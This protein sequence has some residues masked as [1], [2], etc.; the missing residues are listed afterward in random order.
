MSEPWL[1][2][3]VPTYNGAAYLAHTLDSIAMQTTDGVEVI[4]VDDGSS[5]AT[6]SILKSYESR[7]P[8]RILARRR[9]GNWVANTNWGLAQARGRYACFLHQ[10]D[11]W[12]PDR[13][14]MLR[15]WLAREPETTLFLHPSQ[16]ID[17]AGRGLGVWRCPLPEGRLRSELVIEQL[18]VQN[19]VAVPAPVFARAAALRVGGLDEALW[20]TAD[21]DFWLKLAA[22]GP[23]TYHARPLAAFRIHTESQT[24]QG[25]SRAGDMRTQIEIVLQRHLP[26]W[27][28]AN[29]GRGAV[30]RTARMSL[31][32]NHALAAW[33]HGD[34]PKWLTLA[35]DFLA[36]GPAGWHRFFRDSRIVE[37]VAARLLAK[38]YQ[39]RAKPL[40]A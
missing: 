5:D 27:E 39:T 40:A 30:G 8:L 11:L 3:I 38:T 2:V 34:R 36:L 6:L 37:R 35:S 12:L 1:S 13:L 23:T 25:I 10:D 32:V 31:E 18:L 9:I 29:P 19:F 24:A 21:W 22:L 26:R 16:Y 28:A 7:I 14:R 17:A 4:A 33:A 20:Y 15:R